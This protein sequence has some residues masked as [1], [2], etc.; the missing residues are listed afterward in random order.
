MKAVIN[1]KID[2]KTGMSALL[3]TEAF[4][5]FNKPFKGSVYSVAF[6]AFNT[7]DIV[8]TIDSKASQAMFFY[9]PVTIGCDKNFNGG[10]YGAVNSSKINFIHLKK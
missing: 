8:Q 4:S 1:S 10:K 9:A 3:E 2:V 7:K 6:K 5:S